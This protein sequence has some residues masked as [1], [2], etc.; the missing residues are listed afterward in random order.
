LRVSAFHLFR[1]PIGILL[2]HIARSQANA[3][4]TPKV[5]IQALCLNARIAIRKRDDVPHVAAA[6]LINR[7][8]V[9]TNYAKVC[10]QARNFA[11]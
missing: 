7:L 8:I 6:P 4:A 1:E 5:F 10:T 3:F 2:D 11:S 9:V